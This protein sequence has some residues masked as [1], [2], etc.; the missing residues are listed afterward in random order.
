[1]FAETGYEESVGN[2]ATLT[3]EGD[4]VFGDDG[5]ASRLATV[6]GSV[7]AGYAVSLPVRVNTR[8]A[9]TAGS[10]PGGGGRGGGT[11]R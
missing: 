11:P 5:G 6:T 7:G 3:L 4:T 1:M 10:A 2:L 9:P 8:T